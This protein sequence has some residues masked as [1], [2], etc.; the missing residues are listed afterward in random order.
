MEIATCLRVLLM[1]VELIAGHFSSDKSV[2]RA[3]QSVSYMGP[4]T[5]VRELVCN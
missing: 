1:L 3:K 2:Q 4:E 5:L